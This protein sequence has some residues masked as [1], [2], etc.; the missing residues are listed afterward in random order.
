[1]KLFKNRNT[2]IIYSL[3]ITI[4][5]LFSLINSSNSLKAGEVKIKSES[6][7]LGS[8][9][10]LNYISDDR[11]IDKDDLY[12]FVYA[13]DENSTTPKAYSFKLNQTK[14]LKLSTSAL[15]YSASFTL[16]SEV[17]YAY[18]KINEGKNIFIFD[19]NNGNYWDIIYK[20]NGK[21]IR[22]ANLK[23]A[24]SMLGSTPENATRLINLQEAS[25][26]LKQELNSYPDN[27]EAKIALYSLEFDTKKI[28]ADKFK[29]KLKEI[30]QNLSNIKSE[31]EF[32][33]FSRALNILEKKEEVKKI[34][35]DY[36]TK[37]PNSKI[38]E[39]KLVN[40]LTNATTFKE[41]SSLSLDYF[42]KFPNADSYETILT[43]FANSYSQMGKIDEFIA[44]VDSNNYISEEIKL[45]LVSSIIN[46]KNVKESDLQKAKDIYM[47]LIINLENKEIKPIYNRKPDYINEIEWT[48]AIQNSKANF[49]ELGFDLFTKIDK[50]NQTTN[51]NLGIYIDNS[52]NLLA[53][54]LNSGIINKAIKYYSEQNKINDNIEKVNNLY[55]SAIYQS[56][57]NDS[58]IKNYSDFLNFHSAKLNIE[59]GKIKKYIDSLLNIAENKRINYIKFQKLN[60]KQISGTIRK[61]DDTYTELSDLKGKKL[62]INFTSTWCGPCQ[63]LYPSLEKLYLKYKE[64]KEIEIIT[65]DIWEQEKDRDKIISDMLKQIPVAFPIYIDDSDI[66]PS[67]FGVTG[68]PTL[69]VVD[70]NGKIQF[71]ERGYSNEVEFIRNIEDKLKVIE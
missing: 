29:L 42:K 71:I 55:Q 66:I 30:T 8:L 24:V 32:R 1:M 25:I 4:F 45:F 36:E 9:I 21:H 56:V 3:I 46:K 35:K 39:E 16:Q 51:N 14:N 37:F 23:K 33:A 31:G 53:N 69:L 11:F 50:S 44:I 34:E 68:L 59:Q 48:N 10:E 5:T 58:L 47:N 62:I 28:S 67:R 13:Y 70:K 41:F 60:G 61:L 17:I 12:V 38:A 22:N 26:S 6:F 43:A 15:N 18:F 57:Y 63:L 65:I 49:F 54:N 27:N 20:T 64:S 40:N 52:I 2:K 19:D 7:E